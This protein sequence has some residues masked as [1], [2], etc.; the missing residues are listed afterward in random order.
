MFAGGTP[1]DRYVKP[2]PPKVTVSLPL[3]R[4]ITEYD[5]FTG[6]TKAKETV[7]LRARVKGFLKERLFVEKKPVKKGEL[8][9]VID[10]EPF[11]VALAMSKTKL[12]ESNAAVAKAE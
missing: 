5:Q 4:S 10:E 2:A 8:L 9:F 1:S 7:E 12:A 6:T 11:Q 3:K